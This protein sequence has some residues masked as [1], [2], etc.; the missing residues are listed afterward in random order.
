MNQYTE[1]FENKMSQDEIKSELSQCVHDYHRI[2]DDLLMLNMHRP[3]AVEDEKVITSELL[4]KAYEMAYFAR[5]LLG[6]K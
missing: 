4:D 2:Y 5:L 3:S 1:P 6:E